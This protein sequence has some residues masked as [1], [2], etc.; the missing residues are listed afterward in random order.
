[1]G[2]FTKTYS[3]SGCS[4]SW[5][6]LFLNS[7]CIQEGAP[8]HWN[9]K[10]REFLNER[11]PHRWI[12]RAGPQ[13]LTSLYWPP[14]SPDLTPFD[15]F[16][17]GFVKDKVLVRPLPQDLEELKKRITA[18]LNSIT[19][20]MLSRVCQELDYHVDICHFTGGAHIELM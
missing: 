13:D 9:K 20:D 17:W 10:V 1:M 12:G 14:R 7:F 4:P 16:L 15:F 11:L 8:P 6:K 3:L 19:G 18:V 2:T 5:K